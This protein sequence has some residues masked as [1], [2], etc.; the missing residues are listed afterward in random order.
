MEW[1]NGGKRR[2]KKY[3]SIE[4]SFND[5]IRIWSKYYKRYPTLAE[6][7]KWTGNDAPYTWL[8]NVNFYYNKQK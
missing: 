6:A 3:N 5:F 7:R 1:P 2:L 8:N 4:D